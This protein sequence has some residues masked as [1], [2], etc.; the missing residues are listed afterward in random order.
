MIL[1][2][3]F[4]KPLDISSNQKYRD[5]KKTVKADDLFWHMIDDDRLYKEYFFPIGKKLKSLDGCEPETII[6]MFMPMVKD[7]CVEFYKKNKLEGKLA[8]LFPKDLREELCHRL[9]DHYIDDVK[10]G[11]YNLGN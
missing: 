3:F 2:E 5:I 8:K 11:K 4:S 10:S 9:Y 7:G 6:E 1:K